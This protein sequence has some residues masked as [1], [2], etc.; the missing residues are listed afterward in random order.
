[1]YSLHR[2]H[3]DRDDGA[4]GDVLHDHDDGHNNILRHG[5]GDGARDHDDGHSNT[6]RHGHG[7]GDGAHDHDNHM[8][9]LLHAHDDD[10]HVLISP[11]PSTLFLNQ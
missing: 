4:R 3:D 6:P 7:H 11:V 5:R 8:Y 10:V 2:V 1:M 9:I